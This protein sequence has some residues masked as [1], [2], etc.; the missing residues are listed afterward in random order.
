M[1]VCLYV[2]DV[3]V[4]FRCLRGY[5][6]TPEFDVLSPCGVW[7]EVKGGTGKVLFVFLSLV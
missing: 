4:V 7:Q 2:F 1:C 3:H 5:P 6:I